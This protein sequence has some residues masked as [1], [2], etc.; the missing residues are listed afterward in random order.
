M[1]SEAG[2]RAS[3]LKLESLLPE[4]WMRRLSLFWVLPLFS[5]L[6]LA[7]IWATVLVQV[8]EEHQRAQQE[9]L[10]QNDNLVRAFE[11]H[12]SRTIRAVDQSVNFMKYEYEKQA[13]KLDLN[14]LVERGIIQHDIFV[15]LA[16]IRPDGWLQMSNIPSK[17]ID[18]SRREHFLVHKE[19]DNGKLF[20]SK[21]VLGKVSGKW[22]LQFT[23]RINRPDGSF[24]GVAVV[25]VD[26]FYFTDFYENVDIG[27][28]GVITILGEDG[29][30]RARSDR[31][32]GGIGQ[33]MPHARVFDY[34][35]RQSSG[36]YFAKSVLDGIPRYYSFRG[37][38]GYPLVVTMGVAEQDA[39]ADYAHRRA[40]YLAGGVVAS[41]VVVLAAYVL[42]ILALRLRRSQIQAESANRLKSEFLANMSHELRT[43]LN[44][45]L[46]GA[47]YLRQSLREPEERETA[48]LI[49][50]S[51]EHLLS[52][53]N[54]VLDL[55]RIEAG[56]MTLDLMEVPVRKM[57]SSAVEA[58]RPMA[59][60]K[61]LSLSLS[62]EMAEGE[63]E[64]YLLDK[65]RVV[66][67]LNNLL[68][69]ALK[70]TEFGW[71]KV[72]AMVS[73]GLLRFDVSDSGPGIPR[74]HQQYIFERFRQGT[75]FLTRQHGGSGLGLALARN[76]VRLLG[77]Q[78][79]FESV[80]GEGTT[81]RVVL[82]LTKVEPLHA[83][84]NPGGG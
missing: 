51:S 58:F 21:P 9:V 56:R 83:A 84:D 16:I 38:P 32:G 25:S 27:K 6:L 37:V 59:E 43:P 45:I 77:G 7:A 61:K 23:R 63:P 67:I 19:R 49:F 10:R 41:L 42:M 54:S 57:M 30:V 52:L 40:I 74:E 78:I 28:Y 71:V 33:K 68:Q 50:T 29:V 66:Q 11:E 64:I 31:R 20:I 65:T 44:G 60:Q 5:G 15:Q 26:P 72:D 3:R 80:E 14:R 17:P 75:S 82:P 36:H 39:M 8:N 79:S 76:L 34:W 22:S 70:F 4:S 13:D 18:L 46:G 47:D 2:G 48:E 73:G 53:V 55:A 62:L 35:P 24:G 12:V 81:F 1:V 69:N